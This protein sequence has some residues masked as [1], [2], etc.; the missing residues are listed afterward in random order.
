MN[1][2]PQ[3]GINK[4]ILAHTFDTKIL[5]QTI[6]D[7]NYEQLIWHA[8]L[9]NTMNMLIWVLKGVFDHSK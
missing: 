3:T 9:K 5:S 2:Q 6:P 1:G 7:V 4:T 8:E